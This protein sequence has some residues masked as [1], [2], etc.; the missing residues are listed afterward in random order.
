MMP[1]ALPIHGRQAKSNA[2]CKPEC[3]ETKGETNV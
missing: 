1:L 2:R 3:G